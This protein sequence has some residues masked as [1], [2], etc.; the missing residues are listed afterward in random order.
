MFLLRS[1]Y[2]TLLSIIIIL[3]PN[4]ARAST[5]ILTGQDLSLD[6]VYNVAVKMEAVAIA[7]ESLARVK[8][9]HNILLEAAKHDI[10]VYGLNRG[11][12][13]N[14][15]KVIFSGSILEQEARQASEAFNMSDLRATAT[16][17]GEYA[18]PEI[19]RAAM[20]IRLNKLLIGHAG[21]Q[22]RVIELLAE[23]LNHN[24]I[25]L[26]PMKGSVG[27]ADIGILAHMGLALAG[28]GNVLYQNKSQPSKE[29]LQKLQIK[30][31]RP[32][33]KDALG[34]F[35]SNAFSL[36]RAV[37]LSHKLDNLLAN[38]LKI[39]ALSLEGLNGNIAP[40]TQN[41]QNL[42]MTIGQK[43]AAQSILN[44]LT[45][46]YLLE[47]DPNR[48]LQDP[49]SF[50]TEAHVNGSMQDNLK[51]LQQKLRKHINTSDDNPS[52]LDSALGASAPS[53]ERQYYFD[54]ANGMRGAVVPTA[55]FEPLDWVLSL[56]TVKINAA[57]LAHNSAQRTLHLGSYCSTKLNRFLASNGKDIAFAVV[58]K[59]VLYLSTSIAKNAGTITYLSSPLAGNIE[60]T[61]T[62]SGL[63]LDQAELMLEDMHRLA[64]IELMHAAQAVELRMK[65]EDSVRISDKGTALLVKYRK[66]VPFLTVDRALSE[67]LEKSYLFI[68][69][70]E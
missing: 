61:A 25:P 38:Y 41:V 12:G 32:Y 68:K 64:G 19:V 48:A 22:V 33:A 50:R 51:L 2:I 47:M 14:K 39:F 70:V 30:P 29:V 67:D 52:V 23:F 18:S 27:E 16:S 53:N 69:N 20:L 5:V 11:V 59:S 13:L 6:A 37:L 49:L 35:S 10:P 44:E 58:Q 15:D 9:Y 8:H 7:P 62:N 17:F 4:S 40:F 65:S 24:I 46:S 56:E 60:D 28:E 42:S 63:I 66:E 45:R 55:D 21:V 36:A 1:I 57:R 34:I 3:S 31:L 54:N 26:M 43:N